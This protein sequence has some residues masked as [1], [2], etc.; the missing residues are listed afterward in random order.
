[1]E[2]IDYLIVDEDKNTQSS[3]EYQNK[4]KE[5]EQTLNQT[6]IKRSKFQRCRSIVEVPTIEISYDFNNIT[7]Q[8]QI[9]VAKIE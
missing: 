6:K 9:E 5:F 2:K 8:Y 4:I 1:M 7:T 3:K